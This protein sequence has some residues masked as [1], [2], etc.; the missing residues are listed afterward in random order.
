MPRDLRYPR[1]WLARVPAVVFASLQAGELRL[2]LHP[3]AG[4]ADGGVPRDVPIA[5]IPPELRMP[6]TPL[7]IH[8]DDDW[9]IVRVWGR[10]ES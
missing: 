3:G 6:N 5:Q 2:I 8:F 10:E 7:W 9:N 4:L 1:E